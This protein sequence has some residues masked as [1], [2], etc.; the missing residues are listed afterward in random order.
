MRPRLLALLFPLIAACTADVGGGSAAAADDRGSL[1]KADIVGSCEYAGADLCG[2]PGLGNCWCDDACVDFGDCCS[3][4]DDVCGIEPLPVEGQSCGGKASPKC[5][6]GE[7]CMWQPE[8]ICGAS[9]HLG[10]CVAQPQICNKH[11]DPVCGCDGQTYSNACHAA[12]AGTSIASEAACD[13]PKFCG[14]FGNL[15]CG[16]GEQCVDDPNDGCDPMGGG[17]DCGGICVEGLSTCGP[18]E[19]DYVTEL[20][21]IQACTSAD[22]CGQVLAGTSCGCTRNLVARL[23]ADLADLEE[24]RAKAEA[25]ECSVGGISTCDC[26]AV[27]G[28]ACESGVCSWNYV[29]G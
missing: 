5:D 10:E 11:F 9:D 16:E 17:A 13:V 24:I 3:D 20:A 8:D 18:I 28:F 23:D 6:A 21:E 7:F 2:G 29:Q 25:N 1:G 26:P 22:D 12:A 19:N 4:A 14:G 27:D 15:A